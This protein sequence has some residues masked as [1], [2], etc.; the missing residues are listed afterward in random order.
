M[1][2]VRLV[3]STEDLTAIMRMVCSFTCWCWSRRSNWFVSFSWSDD[4]AAAIFWPAFVLDP[5]GYGARGPLFVSLEAVPSGLGLLDG[6]DE[7]SAA[8][9]AVR[10]SWACLAIP[11]NVVALRAAV[12]EA[13]LLQ[14]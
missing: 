1:F 3:P 4:P 12:G 13:V 2:A 6:L 10:P 9:H 5:L 11:L 8:H 14:V 7:A